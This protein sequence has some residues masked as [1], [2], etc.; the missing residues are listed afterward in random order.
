M[1]V[2]GRAVEVEGDAEIRLRLGQLCDALAPGN[3]RREA[4]IEKYLPSV[5]VVRVDILSVCGKA[6][7]E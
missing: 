5:A 3:P 4:V 1:I 6:G 7:R 2:E